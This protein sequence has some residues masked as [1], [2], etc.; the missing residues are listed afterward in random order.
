[1]YI[2]TLKDLQN[3]FLK[4]GTKKTTLKI[5]NSRRTSEYSSMK[6]L[7]E[8]ISGAAKMLVQRNL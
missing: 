7:A 3:F 8:E 6:S 4:N 5:L 1:M 2:C